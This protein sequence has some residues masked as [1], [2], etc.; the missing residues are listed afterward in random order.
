MGSFFNYQAETVRFM[1]LKGSAV[2]L[3]EVL[4]EETSERS[5]L[6]AQGIY[7]DLDISRVILFMCELW[8]LQQRW[9]LKQKWDVKAVYQGQ[10][11]KE[12]RKAIYRAFHVL[13][14]LMDYLGLSWN[15]IEKKHKP[16]L[17]ASPSFDSVAYSQM[18]NHIL[19]WSHAIEVDYKPPEGKSILTKVYFPFDPKVHV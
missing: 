3:L 4:L 2:E 16:A 13:C 19:Q 5:H 10:L 14:K 15:E 6:V 12:A 11:A 1:H 17:T 18:W 8:K 7:H 9:D